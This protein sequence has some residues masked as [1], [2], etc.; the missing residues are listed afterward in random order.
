[1]VV[2]V[3]DLK[4]FCSRRSDA[5]EAFGGRASVDKTIAQYRGEWVAAVERAG[6][7]FYPAKGNHD[8]TIKDSVSR[9]AI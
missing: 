8:F 1:M 4:F 5:P 3:M 6:G 9:K 7:E 2:P